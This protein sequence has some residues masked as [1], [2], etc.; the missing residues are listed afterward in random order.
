MCSRQDEA[1]RTLYAGNLDHRVR[2]E[3]LY[4]LFLQAGPLKK[5]TITRDKDGNSRSF[6][7]VCFQHTESVP[8]A[9]AL[10]NGI[11]LL[12]RPIKLQ[13]RT[14]SSHSSSESDNVFQGTENGFSWTPSNYGMP[15]MGGSYGSVPP[16][17]SSGMISPVSPAYFYFQG[18]MNQFLGLQNPEYS[19][20]AQQQQQQQHGGQFF[21]WN[22]PPPLPPY[23]PTWANSSL[24]PSSSSWYP[25]EAQDCNA[26]RSETGPRKPKRA[27]EASDSDSTDSSL[28]G[29]KSNRRPRKLKAK[30]KR[31]PECSSK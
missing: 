9:I 11:R 5:V 22:G 18:M 28:Q 12:G 25:Q 31:H 30:R 4:E 21:P 2:E 13:Y 15:V 8:Y 17:M 27:A 16:P 6:G 23:T 24:A 26:N 1:D 19:W 20:M 3:T 10:L 29:G 14:G 7:F